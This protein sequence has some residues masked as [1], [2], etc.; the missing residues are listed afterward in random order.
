M[1]EQYQQGGIWLSGFIGQTVSVL[2]VTAWF[3]MLFKFLPDG[4]PSWKTAITGGLFTGLL[5]TIGKILLRWLLTY[6]NMQTIY[7]AS[8]S[9]VLL[10]CLFFTVPLSFTMVPVSPRYGQIHMATLSG[11]ENML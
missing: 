3:T 5:F 6:S 8:T 4:R 11:P 9:S 10:L 7:G 1:P 2:V